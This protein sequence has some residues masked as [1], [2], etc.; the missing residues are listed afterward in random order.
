M[1]LSSARRDAH[2]DDH[3]VGPDGLTVRRLDRFDGGVAAE[4]DHLPVHR[5]GDA[6]IRVQVAEDAR[7]LGTERGVQ[8]RGTRVDDRDV[9][10]EL[11]R[12]GR[13]LRADPTT[14]DHCDV[15]RVC[16]RVA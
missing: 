10:A 1:P 12:R 11:A 15:R 6:V 16:E 9:V 8:R 7:D 5:E 4:R 13:D 2:A 14:A 3:D